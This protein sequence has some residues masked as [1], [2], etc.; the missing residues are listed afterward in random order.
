[1]SAAMTEA[2]IEALVLRLPDVSKRYAFNGDGFYARARLFAFFEPDRP[3]E[4][5]G[6]VLWLPAEARA[7]VLEIDGAR[8]WTMPR[9]S[10]RREWVFVPADGLDAARLARWLTAAREH[11][12]A[13]R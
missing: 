9:T 7:E 3:G 12:L 8:L 2:E 5:G 10:E 6:L 11:A 1:M 13:R 4:S